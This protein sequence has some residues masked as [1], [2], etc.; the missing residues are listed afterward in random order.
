VHLGRGARRD[1]EYGGSLSYLPAMHTHNAG[2]DR[3]DGASRVIEAELRLFILRCARG[4]ERE[5]VAT[6]HAQAPRARTCV[7]RVAGWML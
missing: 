4:G 7:S 5:S 1:G 2:E 6:I 3:C